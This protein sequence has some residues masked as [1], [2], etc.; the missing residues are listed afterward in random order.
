MML[1][2]WDKQ[3][4]ILIFHY[5][6]VLYHKLQSVALHACIFVAAFQE[7]VWARALVRASHD[8]LRQ[9]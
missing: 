8:S 5:T 1:L 3:S 2:I 6:I 4:L 9:L 7:R